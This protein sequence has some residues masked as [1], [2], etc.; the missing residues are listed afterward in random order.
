M[1][2]VAPVGTN[3]GLGTMCAAAGAARRSALET[4]M[5]SDDHALHL[6][7]ALPDL[8][9]LLVAIE[10]GD[11]GLLHVP[12]AAVDLQCRP[13]HACRELAG[14][15]L[16]HR[17]LACQVA[18]RLLQPGGPVDERPPG[19]D[20][21]GHVRELELHRLELRDRLAELLALLR[22]GEREVVRTLREADAH[23]SNGDPP[24]VE[25][26]E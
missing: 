19:L 18:T 22:V 2:S 1:P 4:E 23:G 21:G 20:L 10:P 13:R 17:R 24:A 12:E 9:D 15:V 14:A 25:N 8:E 7:G 11:R 6:I 16:R 5:A 26:L 3:A